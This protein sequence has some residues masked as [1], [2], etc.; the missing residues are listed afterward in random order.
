VVAC[1]V[2]AWFLER[3]LVGQ[4]HGTATIGYLAFGAL[5]NAH[6]IGRGSPDQWWRFVTDGLVHDQT[7]PLH[8]AA[9]SA[10]LIM[11]GSVIERLHGTLLLLSTLVLG[12]VAG[13]LSWMV[14]S[15]L[16]FAA[17][18]DYTAGCS[19]GICA[20][21]GMVLVYGYRAGPSIDPMHAL[22]MKAGATVGVAL[23]LLIGLIVPNLNN[24]A[25]VG[26]LM[27]GAL[28]ALVLPIRPSDRPPQLGLRARA[29]PSSVVVLSV[30]S[31]G[32]AGQNL[33]SRLS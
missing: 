18:P 30:V 9:D 26:G 12:V 19:A 32:F 3:G 20:L 25:H 29:V 33:I 2:G 23:M 10:A 7:S 6:I 1:L 31:I 11:V 28:L 24:V 17:A 4:I 27:C 22:S 14:A 13:G 8:V 21:V 16:G 15:A 5:P